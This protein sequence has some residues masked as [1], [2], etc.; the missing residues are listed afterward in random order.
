VSSTPASRGGLATLLWLVAYSALALAAL[1]SPADAEGVVGLVAGGNLLWG[2]AF[3]VGREE[4]SRSKAAG[5]IVAVLAVA[6]LCEL[7]ALATALAEGERGQ[8]LWFGVALTFVLEGI[9]TTLRR[10]PS[11]GTLA[12]Q[13]LFHAIL[14]VPALGFVANFGMRRFAVGPAVASITGAGPLAGVMFLIV[15]VAVPLLFAAAVTTL[16]YDLS[17]PR[18][19]RDMLWATLVAHEA[20]FAILAARCFP[21]MY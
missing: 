14:L 5:F 9:V 15:S 10:A 12:C 20:A 13:I 3:V 16:A 17:R 1:T 11:D 19:E 7:S 4:R 18:R 6:G 21:G 8:A 2:T